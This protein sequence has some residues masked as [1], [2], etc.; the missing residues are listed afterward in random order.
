[1]TKTLIRGRLLSFRSQPRDITDT[2]SYLFES[3]GAVLVENGLIL[4]SGAYDSVKAE[5]DAQTLEIDQRPHLILPGFVDC[6]V[7]FPQMQVIGSYAANLLE[8]L[9]TYTFPEEC[10][11]VETAHAARIATHFFDEFLRQGTTTA[12]AYCSVHKT[13]A[14]AFFAESA[15]RGTRMIAGKVMMDRNAP[16]GL[17]DTPQSGYDETKELIE[18]WHGRGRNLVAITPRFAITST[19]AQMERTQALAHEFPDLHIQTHLSENREEIDFT[20]SLYPES[21]DYTDIYARY[22]LLG[23]KTLFGHAIHL[24]EREADALAESGSVAVHCP[25]SNLFLGSGLFP[26]KAIQRRT[27][28]VRVA[29]A[30]DIG[31]GTS[32]SMLRTLD[33][34]YKIQQLLGERLNPLD[35]FYHMTLGNAEA[36]SLSDK[37]G[38]LASGT[39]ADLVVLNAHATP[40]MALKMEAVTSLT[41]EL[42]L[43]QTLGDDRVVVETYVAGVASKPRI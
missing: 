30:T 31:G 23:R 21:S 9:N 32:Y 43:M 24:S 42:F 11:F 26:L 14:D 10:R 2:A 29:L 33:E 5:A 4:A 41:E 37:I 19:P 1:M 27:K 38:T 16:Q 8:W 35:S 15:R 39:E 13:S 28:P 34:A 17:L 40:A 3:D 18:S 36:L 12:V 25:T 20:A 6:H 22:G 7:H